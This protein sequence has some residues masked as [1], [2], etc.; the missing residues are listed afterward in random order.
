M[1][2]ALETYYN[3]IIYSN[4]LAYD[5]TFYPDEG[6]PSPSDQPWGKEEEESIISNLLLNLDYSVSQPA[7]VEFVIV[8]RREFPDSASMRIEYRMVYAF[9]NIGNREARGEAEIGLRKRID[10]RWVMTSWAD[11]R[12]TSLSW[13]EIKLLFK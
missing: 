6:L 10:G 5:F 8:S 4:A 11:Y 12:D 1:E 7:D 9:R 2:N 13:G 3:A